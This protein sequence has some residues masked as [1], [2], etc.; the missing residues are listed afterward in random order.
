MEPAWEISTEAPSHKRLQIIFREMHPGKVD[1]PWGTNHSPNA[2]LLNKAMLAFFSPIPLVSIGQ[3]ESGLPLA[4]WALLLCLWSPHL[5]T[6]S[7]RVLLL[8]EAGIGMKMPSG[9]RPLQT[10]GAGL[11]DQH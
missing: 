6:H 10:H 4:P 11:G 9:R 3:R 8:G 5:E 2:P 7:K 1:S